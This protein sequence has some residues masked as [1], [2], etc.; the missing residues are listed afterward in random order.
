MNKNFCTRI[1]KLEDIP[2]K[3][4][5]GYFWLSDKKEPT[6]LHDE[7]FLPRNTINPFIIEGLL[8]CKE[9]NTSYAIKHTGAY[10][11]HEY[12]LNH[13]P[14][15]SELTTEKEYLPHRLGDKVEKVCFKQLWVA[16]PDPLCANMPVL[17]QKAIIFTGFKLK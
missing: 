2:Q 1:D 9:D 5:E 10:H 6:V 4:Y 7:P 15:D 16:E 12:N 17:V 8:H 11:I 13:L 3:L 14:A